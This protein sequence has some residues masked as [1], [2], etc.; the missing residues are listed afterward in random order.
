MTL[1]SQ[2]KKNVCIL[3]IVIVG[4]EHLFVEQLLKIF[5]YFVLCVCKSYLV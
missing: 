2:F 5:Y 3:F 1:E 4:S